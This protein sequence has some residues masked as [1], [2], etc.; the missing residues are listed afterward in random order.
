MSIQGERGTSRADLFKPPQGEG[1]G[2]RRVWVA[3]VL[4]IAGASGA[5]A[6]VPPDMVIYVDCLRVQAKRLDD[7]VSDARTIAASA[8]TA[9]KAVRRD[10]LLKNDPKSIAIAGTYDPATPAEIDIA[11]TVVLQ[12]R[13]APIPSKQPN[14]PRLKGESI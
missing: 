13:R 4:L 3:V 11:A 5:G 14:K 7:R 1:A 10:Y 8:V 12:E 6:Y 9:C 2:M